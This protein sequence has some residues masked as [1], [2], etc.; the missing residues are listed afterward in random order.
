MQN[1]YHCLCICYWV[2]NNFQ[3]YKVC[4][5]VIA[6]WN[7]IVILRYNLWNSYFLKMS[8]CYTVPYLTVTMGGGSISNF[9]KKSARLQSISIRVWPRSNPP[10]YKENTRRLPTALNYYYIPLGSQLGRGRYSNFTTAWKVAWKK[11]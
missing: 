10:K 9:A 7:I 5:H 4:S 2:S 3:E 11:F 1:F 6:K 8:K